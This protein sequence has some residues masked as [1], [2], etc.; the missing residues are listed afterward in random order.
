RCTIPHPGGSPMSRPIFAAFAALALPAALFAQK[1]EV[2]DGV[3][4]QPL[5]ENATRLVKALEQL[6]TPLPKD[7]AKAVN[8]A[9]AA[10]DAA[11][12]QN[13]LDPHVLIQV[14]LN[15]ESRVKAARGP[16]DAVLQQYGVTPVILKIAND[17][18][19]KKSLA[20]SSPQAGPVYSG[21]A[22]RVPKD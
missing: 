10:R 22:A 9:A 14:S 21:G 17:S 18:T 4:G 5:G 8:D 16:A 12:I 15:P 11:A 6:G 13:L 20:I 19:V 1:L 2:I 3:E 7:L